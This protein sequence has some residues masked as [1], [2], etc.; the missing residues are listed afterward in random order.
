MNT[1]SKFIPNLTFGLALAMG[2]STA[3][4]AGQFS[5]YQA[6]PQRYPERYDGLRGVIERTQQDL[7]SSLALEHRGGEQRQRYN[8]AQ[9]HLSTFDRHLVRG[10]FDRGELGKAMGS[11]R[12]ILNKNVLEPSSRDMLTRDLDELYR[13][14]DRY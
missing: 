13:I 4:H 2:M 3:L 5:S 14:H 1:I 12:A 10:R 11:I 9:G 8:D 7:G 6:Y